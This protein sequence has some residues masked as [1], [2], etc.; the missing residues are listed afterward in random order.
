M[1]LPIV[2]WNNSCIRCDVINKTMIKTGGVVMCQKCHEAIFITPNPVRDQRESYL[3]W[4]KRMHERA[5][6]EE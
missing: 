6:A 5:E 1:S 2:I 4:L 3:A